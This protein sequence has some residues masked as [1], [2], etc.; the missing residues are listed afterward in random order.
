MIEF[1]ILS[2]VDELFEE[3]KEF[4]RKIHQ[5]PELSFQE[6]STSK[7]ISEK[8][9]EWGIPN[10][11]ALRNPAQNP[12]NSLGV[13]GEIGN[14]DTC[15]A[16][17]A[18]IDALPITETTGLGF[19]SLNSGVM[20]ACGHDMHTAMLLGAAKI[21][22]ANENKL[23]CKIILIFQPAEELLPG[24]AK[25]ILDSGV[26]EKYNIQAIF[27]QHI[28]PE[29]PL[30]KIGVKPG[31]I[32][33]STDELHIE[34][35]GKSTHAAQ[36]HLGNDV[37]LASSNLIQYYNTIL[38]KVKNP[39]DSAIISVTSI[40]AGSVTNILPDSAKL[41]GTMRTYSQDLRKG[42]K[43]KIIEDSSRIVQL[44]GCEINLNIIEGYPPV[45]NND[46]TTE[47]FR[48]IAE[49]EIGVDN[50]ILQEAKM[51][52]EDFAY[53]SQNYPSVFWFLGVAAEGS[54]FFPLHNPKLSP[55]EDALIIGTLLF[56]SIGLNFKF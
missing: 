35:K 2:K 38:N 36:P 5:N 13:I 52:A 45:F 56:V 40:H 46:F 11:P 3:I 39:L 49:K 6:I 19:T 1:N 37:I 41:L 12:E 42:I 25:L 47:L 17:R 10:Y 9:N 48:T 53:Y 28:N 26:L 23:Y 44:Y 22:K 27:G 31:P 32:M 21:L 18:D 51:W 16:F 33:A 14:G 29:I 15:I 34:I 50:I 8:L 20:H 55:S 7:F 43:S 4:R 24:G 54:E 30:G